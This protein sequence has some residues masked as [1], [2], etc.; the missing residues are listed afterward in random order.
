M[1]P[2]R[3]SVA[4]KKAQSTS[5]SLCESKGNG[6]VCSGTGVEVN[7]F[8]DVCESGKVDGDAVR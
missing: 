6:M 8:G 4:D 2:G 7:V 1:F 5:K 3:P